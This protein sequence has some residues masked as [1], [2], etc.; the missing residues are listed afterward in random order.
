M[1]VGRGTLGCREDQGRVATRPGA[2]RTPPRVGV[3]EAG[4][5]DSQTAGAAGSQGQGWSEQEGS[6][7]SFEGQD[8]R[9]W[10]P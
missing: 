4:P 9:K 6:P 1:P 10:S 7:G 5:S 2:G 8:Q 3:M